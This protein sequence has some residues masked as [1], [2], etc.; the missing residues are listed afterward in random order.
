MAS[1]HQIGH[2]KKV[3]QVFWITLAL[4]W[5]VAAAELWWG[6][7]THSISLT[8]DGFH[9]L[10]DGSSNI[11]GIIA[12]SYAMKPPD[13]DHPYGHRKFEALASMFISL[14]IFITCWEIFSQTVMRLFTPDLILPT[15]SMG[16]YLIKL[17]GLGMNLFVTWYERK[18]AREYKSDLLLA[19]AQHTTSDIY[20][21]LSVLASFVA[22]QVG[23]HWFDIIVGLVVVYFIFRAGWDIIMMHMGVLMD[24]AVLDAPEVKQAVMTVPGVKECHRIRSRG[25]SDNVFIDLH[26]HVDQNLTIREGHGIA[27]AVEKKI[28][29]VFGDRVVEVLVHVEDHGHDLKGHTE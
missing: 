6:Y 27:H 19:D 8:A 13:D 12:L 22:I 18:K 21:S 28:H 14:F 23:W 25:M 29:E 17:S 24:E 2:L 7:R 4:N 16:S 10:L 15:V 1:E 3:R 26:I 9:S 11:I 5:L 20:V